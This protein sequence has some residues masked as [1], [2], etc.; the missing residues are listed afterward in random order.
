MIDFARYLSIW[1][2]D[3]RQDERTFWKTMNPRR[4]HAL[5]SVWQQPIKRQAQNMPVNSAGGKPT[6]YIDFDEPITEQRNLAEYF[7]RG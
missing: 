7:M 1:M 3:L 6:H 5:L 4:M 2:F